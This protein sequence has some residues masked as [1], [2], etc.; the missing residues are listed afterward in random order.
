MLSS[1]FVIQAF[2]FDLFGALGQWSKDV[3][4]LESSHPVQNDDSQGHSIGADQSNYATLQDALDSYG[5]SDI[6]APTWLPNGFQISSVSVSS[7]PD[8]TIFYATFENGDLFLSIRYVQYGQI[9]TTYNYTYEKD[10]NS[11]QQYQKNG[12]IHY[13]MTNLNTTE[14]VWAFNNY[15]CAIQGDVSEHDLKSMIDS[16]SE[17]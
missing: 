15:E 16:I 12:I 8:S 7:Q 13:I 4:Y 6:S 10:E 5:I 17:G 1:L 2:G 9:P 11:I 14:V 3:F